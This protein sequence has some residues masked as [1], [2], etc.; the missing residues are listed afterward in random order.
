MRLKP[1]FFPCRMERSL[2]FLLFIIHL[3]LKKHFQTQQIQYFAEGGRPRVEKKK[4]K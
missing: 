2:S 4:D 3:M 1:D